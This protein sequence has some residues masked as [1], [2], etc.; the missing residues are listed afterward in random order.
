MFE[1][2]ARLKIRFDSPTGQLSVED[3]WDLPLTGN[4]KRANLDDIAIGLDK[5]LKEKGTTSFVK[6]TTRADETLTLKFDIVRKVIEVKLAEAEAADLRKSNAE[7][8]QKLL[9]ILAEKQDADLKGKST[10]ELQKL[11]NELT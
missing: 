9:A 3:L 1:K 4:N 5:D 6:K 8:K 7:R 2:A 11:I 10:E